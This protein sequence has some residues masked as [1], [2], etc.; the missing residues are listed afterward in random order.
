MR[1]AKSSSVRSEATSGAGIPILGR[2]L[3]SHRL[4]ALASPLCWLQRL[5]S[6]GSGLLP[7][8]RGQRGPPRSLLPR[9]RHAA[10][11][12]LGM[13]WLPS[14]VFPFRPGGGRSRLRR[15]LERGAAALEARRASPPGASSG[16]LFRAAGRR[17]GRAGCRHRLSGA[18]PSP[19]PARPG[20]QPSA[21]P[22]AVG[23][24]THAAEVGSGH[25]LRCSRAHSRYAVSRACATWPSAPAR[26]ERLP[27]RAARAG[28][29]QTGAAGR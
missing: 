21:R 13:P 2:D 10:G 28:P 6:R 27:G 24:P 29:R 18:A 5:R 16:G 3:G 20:V 4:G 1:L 8:L 14:Y 15:R 23:A 7:D 19:A 9:L 17:V 11:W 25:R 26:R 12:G 22:I